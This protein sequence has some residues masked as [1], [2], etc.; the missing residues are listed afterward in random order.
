MRW[1]GGDFGLIGVH[2]VRFCRS[3]GSFRGAAHFMHLTSHRLGGSIFVSS[4]LMVSIL[5]RKLVRGFATGAAY[6][7]GFGGFAGSL[8]FV[9]LLAPVGLL[10][11]KRS[12]GFI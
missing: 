8:A 7:L 1:L 3:G 5:L 9:F 2:S 10:A 11:L 4:F 12:F 6:H